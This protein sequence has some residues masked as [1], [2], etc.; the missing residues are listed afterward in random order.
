MTVEKRKGRSSLLTINGITKTTTEWAEE[1]GID[2]ITLSRRIRDGWSEDKLFQK[3]KPTPHYSF[4]EHYFDIID[5]E[6]KAYWIGFIWCDGYMAIRN[7]NNRTS[8]EFK[9]TL[10]E[11]DYG[12]LEKF[13]K[14][15][16]GSYKVNFYNYYGFSQELCTEAR[17]L[18]TN[19]HFG[20]TLVDQYGLIPY[21]SDCSKIIQ[22]I[23]NSLMKHF[24][25]GV[26]DA[27]GAFC[28]YQIVDKGYNVNKY[29]VSIGTNKDILR[30]IENHLMDNGLINAFERKLQ[31]R[32]IDGDGEYRILEISGKAQCLNVLN[33]IYKDAEIYLDRKYDK[34]LN[35]I[36]GE[37]VFNSAV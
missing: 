3:T 27:D 10:K 33:Y 31:Q 8:Y 14:D 22:S 12:H 36:G 29:M 26:I 35:I 16:D 28:K 7:R 15:I 17:L 6:H 20:K 32:H 24:I 11:D 1:T 4:N 19:Q 23:P 18:I 30:V 13:N 9:L 21:R 25:R 2:T 5:D 37:E 34:Y